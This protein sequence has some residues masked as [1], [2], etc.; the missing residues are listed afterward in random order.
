M[1]PISAFSR[2]EA[3]FAA[4]AL[5]TS[6]RPAARLSASSAPPSGLPRAAIAAP[7]QA[8]AQPGSRRATPVKS[9]ASASKECSLAMASCSAGC[10]AAAQV[11][12]KLTVP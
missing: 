7:H 12:A 10:T 5:S 2:G 6:R 4:R 11:L 3:F 8:M 9:E 1:A